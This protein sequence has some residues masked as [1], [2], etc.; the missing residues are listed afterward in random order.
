MQQ[1]SPTWASRSKK[2]R[3]MFTDGHDHE[4]AWSSVTQLDAGQKTQW[5]V[6]F[7]TVKRPTYFWSDFEHALTQYLSEFSI[8][9][10][11]AWALYTQ[12]CAIFLCKPFLHCCRIA[13]IIQA[14][15]PSCAN[16]SCTIDKPIVQTSCKHFLC[17][18]QHEQN[19]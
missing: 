6:W 5:L 13:Q 1:R 15:L 3:N 8:G 14:R 16:Y 7:P 10:N 2:R 11:Y 17:E 19:H 12:S 9:L 4:G 18:F